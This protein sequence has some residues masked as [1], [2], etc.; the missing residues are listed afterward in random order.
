MHFQLYN[1]YNI[2]Y[3]EF[4]RIS[5]KGSNSMIK[6]L[7]MHM[8]TQWTSRVWKFSF[9]SVP[10]HRILDPAFV[11]VRLE[12]I[13]VSVARVTAK[14]EEIEREQNPASRHFLERITA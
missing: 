3:Y 2:F 1:I 5:G 4:Y 13:G 6:I 7:W 12:S 10:A 9:R 14:R 11:S 8:Y